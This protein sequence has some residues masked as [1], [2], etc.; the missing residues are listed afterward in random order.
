MARPEQWGSRLGVI[1]AVAGSAVGL[2]NFLRFPGKAAQYDGA[3]F[4][5]PYFISLLI[6]GIPLMWVEWT[7]GRYGGKQGYN[8]SPGIFN[9]LGPRPYSKFFGVIGLIIPVV[10][11]MYYVFIESWCLGYAWYFLTGK[12]ASLGRDV[13]AY[14]TFFSDYVG[15]KENGFAIGTSPVMVFLA[16]TF[17]LNF[18]V[19]YRGLS[20]GIELFCTYALP[21][22]VVIGIIVVVRVLTLGTPDAAHPGWNV[23]NGLG[24]L[25]NP[26]RDLLGA[27]SNGDMWLEAAGQIFFS[28]SVGFGVVLNYASYLKKE[29]DVVLSGTTAAS[30]NE[31]CEVC[32]GGLITVTAA[33]VFLGPSG[34]EGKGTFGLG[35]NVLPCIFAHM[36]A[37]SFFGFLFFILLFLAAITSSLSMLQPAIAFLEEGFGLDRRASVA[38]LGMFTALGSLFVVYFSKGFAA[39]DTMDFWIGSVLIFIFATIIAIY[40]AWVLGIEKGWR[41]MHEGA[42]M[43]VPRVFKFILRWVSPVYLLGI[44]TYWSWKNFPAR[45]KSIGED[46]IVGLTVLLLIITIAFVVLLVGIAGRRWAQRKEG[47]S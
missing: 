2:G 43:R 45:L 28:L 13:G 17:I 47:E 41:E 34:I 3:A 9:V 22:L 25:W 4:L 24:Y 11:Y 27:L 14:E 18:W 30:T 42:L 36:P 31:F 7:L 6:L 21:M 5:I 19:I 23:S 26:P 37:G 40:F 32:L 16:I 38:S 46:K 12:M 29:D 35:F 39:L 10:I 44:F 33:F 1:L 8:S 20:R 15:L